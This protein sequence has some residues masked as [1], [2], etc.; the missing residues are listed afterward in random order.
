MTRLLTIMATL[1]YDAGILEYHLTR[2][3][4]KNPI[5]VRIRQNGGVYVSAN[6]AVSAKQLDAYLL[7]ILPWIHEHLLGADDIPQAVTGIDET[8]ANISIFG[9]IYT[10]RIIKSTTEESVALSENEMLVHTKA[11]V[12]TTGAEF[13][14]MRFL[15]GRGKEVF[16]GLLDTYFAKSGYKGQKPALV[17][18]TLKSKWGHYHPGKNEIFI[19]YALCGLSMELCAYV[20]AH[21]VL[22]LFIRGHN[23]EFYTLGE[24][25]YPGFKALDKEL[26]R[27]KPELWHNL[28][29]GNLPKRNVHKNTNT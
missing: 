14:I 7:S 9:K 20:V 25:L 18:K 27:Y 26:N 6:P 5:R 16:S 23:H 21:E 17:M 4:A 8:W 24:A 22:H 12:C 1:K 29:H 28:K 3:T 19:N 15:A 10:L 2:R 13:L 11:E